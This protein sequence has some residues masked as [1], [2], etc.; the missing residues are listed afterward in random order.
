M[1]DLFITLLAPHDTIA[2]WPI[3]F[4]VCFIIGAIAVLL[5]KGD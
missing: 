5:H 2:L 4:V 1:A 3:I